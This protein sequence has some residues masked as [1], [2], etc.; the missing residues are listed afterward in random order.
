MDAHTSLY[1]TLCREETLYEAWKIVKG[2]NAA[3]GI[4][5]VTLACFEDDL[6]KYIAEL[7]EELE[8]LIFEELKKE[9]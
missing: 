2:K 1:A 4:D 5:G 9:K 8:R 6:A 7:S 3:G